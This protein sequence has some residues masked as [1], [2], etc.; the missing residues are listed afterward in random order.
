L[1]AGLKAKIAG[2]IDSGQEP[3]QSIN[4]IF[5]IVAGLY[6][7][8]GNALEK[9]KTI[10]V[11]HIDGLWAKML[12][13]EITPRI[14]G[15]TEQVQILIMNCVIAEISYQNKALRDLPEKWAALGRRT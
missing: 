9:L 3:P 7:Y 10:G 11:A 6:N 1:A 12:F 13:D 15:L 4:S 2:F 14:D 5:D 8:S